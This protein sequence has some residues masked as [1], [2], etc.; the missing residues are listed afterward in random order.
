MA[1]IV[2]YKDKLNSVVG[3]INNIVTSSNNLNT[4]LGSL[5]T[6]LQ[7]VSSSTCNLRE[8]VDNISS[9]TKTEKEKVK[10]LKKLN[11]KVGEFISVAVKKDNSAKEQ[12]EKTKEEFYTKYSYLKP[13]CEK[14]TLEKI[15][16]GVLSAYE[17]CA[18]NWQII[19]SIINVIK[20]IA[21][22]VVIVAASVATFGAAAVIAAAVVGAVVGLSCQFVSDAFSA[23]ASGDWDAS[24]QDYVGSA[25]GGAVGGILMLTGNA[26]LACT[27]DAG[28]SSF[29][30][31]HLSNLTGGEKK[32]SLS[33]MGDTVFS[34]G[35]TFGL[36]KM[37]GKP[38]NKL[39]N[40][41]S[42]RFSNIHMLKRLAGQG[43]YDAAFR[44]V[45]TRLANN[46]ATKFTWKTIR[47]GI[48]AG[49][50]DS[51]AENAVQGGISGFSERI[52][53]NLAKNND[54]IDISIDYSK[55]S[56][57]QY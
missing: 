10:D 1:T 53:E 27:V 21:V 50:T 52:S 23:A 11:K 12:I 15:C 44:A 39:K 26:T 47:N 16:D 17:W 49:M 9:S 14:S 20:V 29:L 2:L 38:V 41:L 22:V 24:W 33:I 43:N 36:G 19:D 30:S 3:L 32:S 34:A 48:V 42:I 46:N 4:Q 57:F 25:I 45:T 8:T 31:G 55:F 6:T 5:K 51:Y 18:E 54:K 13:D 40:T 7:G 28:I 37:L 56:S 35:L